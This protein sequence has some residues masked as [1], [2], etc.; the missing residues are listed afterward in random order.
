MR[1][2][3]LEEAESHEESSSTAMWHPGQVTARTALTQVAATVL[4]SDGRE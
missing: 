3:L 2:R 1:D 4:N